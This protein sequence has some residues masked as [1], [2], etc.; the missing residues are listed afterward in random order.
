MPAEPVPVAPLKH[1]L[2]ALTSYELQHAIRYL[3]I[4]A[5]PCAL[6]LLR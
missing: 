2:S 3:I 1:P 4:R 6:C 5:R